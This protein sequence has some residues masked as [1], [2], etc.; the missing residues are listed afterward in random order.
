MEILSCCLLVCR[1]L[2]AQ[3]RSVGRSALLLPSFVLALC[4]AR[5]HFCWM[6]ILTHA[7]ALIAEKW[8]VQNFAFFFFSSPAARAH[9]KRPQRSPNAQFERSVALNLGPQ[10]NEKTPEG[11]KKGEMWGGEDSGGG[12]GSRGPGEVGGG[13]QN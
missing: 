4:R 11:A 10:F 7:T 3:C 9:T 12:G 2:S 1:A 6:F 5:A 8:E 13:N